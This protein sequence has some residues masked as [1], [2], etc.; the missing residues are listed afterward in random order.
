MRKQKAQR[1]AEIVC[2]S[3]RRGERHFRNCMWDSVSVSSKP[4][5][6]RSDAEMNCNRKFRQSFEI[7]FAALRQL[8]G[9]IDRTAEVDN[10]RG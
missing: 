5:S 3:N 6:R 9:S 2:G 10:T 4:T 8:C 1:R 7:A